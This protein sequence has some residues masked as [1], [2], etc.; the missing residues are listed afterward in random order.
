MSVLE[1][2]FQTSWSH[3]QSAKKMANLNLA[4]ASERVNC[5]WSRRKFALRD[6]KNGSGR[7]MLGSTP[8]GADC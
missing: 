3:V 7:V 5:Q 1:S 2:A 6:R 8:E 4:N